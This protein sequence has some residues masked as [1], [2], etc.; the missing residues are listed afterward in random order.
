MKWIRSSRLLTRGQRLLETG[1]F[2]LALAALDDGLRSDSSNSGLLLYRGL[3]LSELGRHGEA[4]AAI[5][6]AM[7]LDPR[8]F[9][10]PMM[11]GRAR[12]DA[13][14][15][16][17]ADAALSK[18]DRMDPGNP[19]IASMRL[20]VAYR[21]GAVP[22]LAGLREQVAGLPAAF[23]ARVLASMPAEPI[24]QWFEAPPYDRDTRIEKWWRETPLARRLRSRRSR[25]MK[26]RVERLLQAAR[27]EDV[28]VLLDPMDRAGDLED[29]LRQSLQRARERAVSELAGKS[30]AATGER[31]RAGGRG[32]DKAKPGG[33]RQK[34]RARLE[35]DEILRVLELRDPRDHR[36]LRADCR[37]WLESF[38]GDGEPRR[39]RDQASGV[40]AE[41]GRLD[42]LDGRPGEAIAHCREA[43]RHGPSAESDWTEAVASLC[44]SDRA[45]A[46]RCF[47]RFARQEEIE[48]VRR[49]R[50]K[51]AQ[52][53]PLASHRPPA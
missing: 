8:N 31:R 14:E 1:E 15:L 25:L 28:I 49:V 39:D 6:Q 11:L 37:K 29:D 18:A 52:S 21:R 34:N 27:W 20:L 43:R 23:S 50:E 44:S 46:R 26:A 10:M 3:A 5:E 4:A 2:A 19:L 40:L 13:D 36:A 42:A 48:F 7:A 9:V 51:L 17:D 41:L 38:K 35:R 33:R 24:G 12:M 16:A 45:A 53:E 22:T 32:P 30:A 47:E